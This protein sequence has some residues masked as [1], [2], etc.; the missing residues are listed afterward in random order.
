MGGDIADR[1][2]YRCEIYVNRLFVQRFPVSVKGAVML[3]N[4]SWLLGRGEMWRVAEDLW[5]PG[6]Y[7]FETGLC[8]FPARGGRTYMARKAATRFSIGGWV[9]NAF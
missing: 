8:L 2:A 1:R 4:F 7:L 5:K 6:L 3:P 9:E